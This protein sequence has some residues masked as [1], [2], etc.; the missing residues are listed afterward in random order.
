MNGEG[1]TPN[2]GLLDQKSAIEWVQRYI[3]HFGGDK[4]RVTLFGES[5]GAGS[6]LYHVTAEASAAQKPFSG[7]IIQSPYVREASSDSH[8]ANV[9][10]YGNMSSLDELRHQSTEDLQQLNAL[11]VGNAKPFGNFV[12]GMD[13]LPRTPSGSNPR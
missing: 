2:A 5:A 4:D 11:L 1:V 8:V 13:Y 3:G 12:F 6:I 7:A 9:L 10:H